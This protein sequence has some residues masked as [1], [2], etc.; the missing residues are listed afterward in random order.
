MSA[1]TLRAF[2]TATP[3]D[4][5]PLQ[6]KVTYVGVQSKPLPTVVFSTFHH[7]IAMDWF[8]RLRRP[9]LHYQNDEVAL[10]NF[11]VTPEEMF[12][13]V[14]ALAAP[15]LLRDDRDVADP[16][17]SLMIVIKQSRLG[18]HEFE[19]LF[20]RSRCRVLMDAIWGAVA[21]TNS[22]GA[23]VLDQQRRLLCA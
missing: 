9:G 12:R 11:S 7:L 1:E 19:A 6:V 21:P 17:L 23:S 5:R 18:D 22:L 10:W 20:D 3:T 15:D 2:A 13:V 4:L 14:E 8:T 16:A